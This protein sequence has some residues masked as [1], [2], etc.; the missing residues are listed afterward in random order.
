MAVIGLIFLIAGGSGA[1]NDVDV[2]G[3]PAGAG[4]I[5][6]GIGVVFLLMGALVIFFGV[7]AFKGKRWGAIGLA[8]LAGLTVIGGISSLSQGDGSGL[9]GVIWS[10]VGAVLLLLKSSQDYYRSKA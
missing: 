7:M 10:V 2:P 6:A 1:L 5:F 4:S 3:F 8:V 9:V